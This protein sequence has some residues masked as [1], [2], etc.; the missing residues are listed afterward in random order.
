MAQTNETAQTP[1][2]R[3]EAAVIEAASTVLGAQRARDPP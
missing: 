1:E 2:D 3:R